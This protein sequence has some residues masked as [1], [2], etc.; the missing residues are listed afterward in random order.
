MVL[1][2]AAIGRHPC[3]PPIVI[4]ARSG[5]DPDDPRAIV[6]IS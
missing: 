6:T 3:H 5:C 2:A 1:I 4:V